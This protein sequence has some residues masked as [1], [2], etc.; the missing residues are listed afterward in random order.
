[1]KPIQTIGSVPTIPA[2][3]NTG[4][5]CDIGGYWYTT[6]H[7]LIQ[8]TCREMI[9]I[10]CD[11]G[12]GSFHIA[13]RQFTVAPG[14][15]FFLPANRPHGYRC[16]PTQGWS[17]RWL[18]FAGDHAARLCRLAGFTEATP[19]QMLASS[20]DFIIDFDHTL[21]AMQPGDQ[22]AAW[23]AAGQ[24]TCML[25]RV[26]AQQVNQ[27]QPLATPISPAPQSLEEMAQAAGLSRHHFCRKFK[28]QTG[29]TPWRFVMDQKLDQARELLLTTSLSIKEIAAKL[30]FSS[31][32]Y[33]SRS[34]SKRFSC[35][36]SQYRGQSK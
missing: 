9:L 3:Q 36:P 7:N 31:P 6:Q 2:L 30:D 14:H 23:R 10:H 32:D 1:M 8:R 24:L 19:L 15:T 18:H 28:Q 27:P 11:Q 34:F 33:F 21:E 25:M 5:W 20:N 26:I 35:S 13:N 17:I 29:V 12:S 4:V 16:H 22:T